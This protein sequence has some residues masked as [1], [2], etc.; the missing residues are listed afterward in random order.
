MS[1]T[2]LDTMKK[3]ISSR[4]P[5]KQEILLKTSRFNKIFVFE[6]VD[7]YPVYDEWMKLNPTYIESGHLVAKG[8]SQIIELYEHAMEHNDQEILTTCYFFVDHDFDMFEHNSDGIV[9]LSC[10]SIENYI[11]NSHSAKSY[12]KDEFKMDI[13][14]SDLL[15][16][17][18][19]DFENDF[20]IFQRLAK[21]LCRPLFVNHNANGRAK[22][23]DKISTVLN[24]EY[25]N[26]RMKDSAKL[27]GYEV[28]EH[29]TEVKDLILF[30]DSLSYERSIRGKYVFEFIKCWLSSLKSFL[31]TNEGVRISKDPLML[32]RRRLAC[33]TPIPEEMARFS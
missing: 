20:E 26:I 33:A 8:K 31:L 28:N 18:R 13:T 15:E 25:K 12:L 2:L 32:E 16:A 1:T 29:S 19:S 6:G 23:Y 3:E 11:I 9:T 4:N 14:R 5:L 17:I 30:F 24:L 10:Y 22:F 7:D 27:I 21:E